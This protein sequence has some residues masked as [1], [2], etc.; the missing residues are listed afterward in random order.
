MRPRA[1]QGRTWRGRR[2]RSRRWPRPRRRRRPKPQ[3]PDRSSSAMAPD[4]P[5]PG[6]GLRRALAAEQ[7]P[8]LAG[9]L[10][11][12]RRAY[13]AFAARAPDKLAELVDSIAMVGNPL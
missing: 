12:H 6:P 7:D 4:N 8:R 3:P 5:A 9:D 11:Q 2:H 13:I 10:R 1:E